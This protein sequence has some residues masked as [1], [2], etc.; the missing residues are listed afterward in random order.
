[1][2]VHLE[3]QDI[4][5][6]LHAISSDKLRVQEAEASLSVKQAAIAAM[7]AVQAKLAQA[8]EH[9]DDSRKAGGF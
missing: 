6:L 9:Y 3:P 8:Q 5:L 2:I 7:D 4:T 1:M